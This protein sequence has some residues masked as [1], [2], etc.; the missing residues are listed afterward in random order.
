ML[1]FSLTPEQRAKAGRIVQSGIQG[2]VLCACEA[3]I[4]D[5]SGNQGKWPEEWDTAQMTVCSSTIV[6]IKLTDEQL[7]DAASQVQSYLCDITNSATEL[8]ESLESTSPEGSD[9]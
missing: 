3:P 7:L 2:A 9:E 6:R 8:F 4:D 5:K 1:E